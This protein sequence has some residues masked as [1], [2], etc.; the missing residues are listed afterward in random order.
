MESSPWKPLRESVFLGERD[1]LFGVG[2]PD[3]WFAPIAAHPSPHTRQCV[4]EAEQMSGLVG[5]T[6]RLFGEL[7]RFLQPTEQ[8]EGRRG[9]GAQ[10]GVPREAPQWDAAIHSLQVTA[11]FFI[12]RGAL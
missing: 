8:L 2:K 3:L 9:V 12:V 11:G 4:T 7:C 5:A 10:R 6:A 1:R